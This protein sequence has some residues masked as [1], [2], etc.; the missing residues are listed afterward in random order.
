MATNSITDK[1]LDLSSR[2]TFAPA[3]LYGQENEPGT[4]AMANQKG[5][6]YSPIHCDMA[7][8]V[9]FFDE[10]MRRAIGISDEVYRLKDKA[11][12]RQVPFGVRRTDTH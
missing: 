10:F 4:W 7:F 11:A 3:K 12:N 8:T 6:I 2:K 5:M 1:S 9:P